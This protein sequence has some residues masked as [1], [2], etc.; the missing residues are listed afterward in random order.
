MV[1]SALTRSVAVAT[2]QVVPTHCARP[3]RPPEATGS[4]GG[5]RSLPVPRRSN[6][7]RYP[8][9]PPGHPAPR[10]RRSSPD[11]THTHRLTGM[12]P[13][14]LGVTAQS[15]C[16][17]TPRSSRGTTFHN[18]PHTK[19]CSSL[20]SCLRGTD[21]GGFSLSLFDRE[22]DRC[23]FDAIIDLTRYVKGVAVTAYFRTCSRGRG[24]WS[25]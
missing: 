11:G 4:R 20:D 25:G 16:S 10:P 18:R 1:V 22:I 14:I 9:D 15:C 3:A 8:Q 24:R 13:C 23:L 12:L 5:G 17:A 6:A 2:V 19:Q 21:A 7:T